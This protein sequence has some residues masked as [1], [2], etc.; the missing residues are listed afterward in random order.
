MNTSPS[1]TRKELANLYGA[2]DKTF[3]TMLRR[4][5]LDFGTARVLTPKQIGQIVQAFGHW[6]LND[7]NYVD[8]D[9]AIIRGK[10]G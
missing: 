5:E 4:D 10:D 1:L 3:C 8:H 6:L 7:L 9:Q 2:S